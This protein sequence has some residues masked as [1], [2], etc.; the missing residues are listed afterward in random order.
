MAPGEPTREQ[1]RAIVEH[2]C[3]QTTGSN[4]MA[5][6]LSDDIKLADIGFQSLEFSEAVMEVE[7][8]VGAELNFDAVPMREI[9]TVGALLDFLL[10]MIRTRP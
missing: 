4:V 6:S 5:E 8:L 7:D 10:S 2:V 1:L 3:S 9:V